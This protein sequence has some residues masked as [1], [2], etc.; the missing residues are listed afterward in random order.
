MG[1]PAQPQEQT[2]D[3]ILASIRRMIADDEF[4][5]AGEPAD[6]PPKGDPGRAASNVSRLFAGAP[7]DA[8]TEPVHEEPPA[9]D[10][11]VVE[12]AMAQAFEEARAEVAAAGPETGEEIEPEEPEEPEEPGEP[13]MPPPAP[14]PDRV[15]EARRMAAN[16]PGVATAPPAAYSHAIAGPAHRRAIPPLPAPAGEDRRPAPLLSANSDAAVAAA[17]DQLAT[18]ML[19]G[20]A[21]TID[22]LAE[23]LL[24][25][26]LRD[27]LDNNLPPMVERLVREE[28]ER[29]SRGRR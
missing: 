6:S 20:G 7:A 15:R 13:P 19:S 12:L 3:E 14:L 16:S 11:N 29:V 1:K 24:R 22:E 23:D 27:W 5:K 4:R 26:M 17:F 8:K 10:D 18:T 28:I 9:V 25:P 2:M 21:R